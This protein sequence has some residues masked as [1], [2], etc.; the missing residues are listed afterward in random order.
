LEEN[1]ISHWTFVDLDK[2]L[3]ATR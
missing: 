2:A 3:G 1:T